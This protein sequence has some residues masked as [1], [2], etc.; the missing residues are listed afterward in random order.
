MAP[1][2]S[3]SDPTLDA[4]DLAQEDAAQAH[5]RRTYLG[6]SSIGHPCSRKLWYDFHDPI[7]ERHD[8]ATLR[9]F[10]DGDRSEAVLI[11]RLRAVS[12]VQLWT[13]DP[14]SGGQFEYTDFDGKFAGHLDGVILGILQAPKT[15]HVWEAKCVN[16]KKFA[17]LRELKDSLG[18][19][20]AF[21]KWDYVYWAQAQVYMRY[22]EL[23][24]H[25]LTVCTPGARA[26]DS[27]RTNFDKAAAEA[28]REKAKRIIESPFQLAKVSSD[29][30]WYQCRWCVYHERC[31]R[32]D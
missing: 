17:K 29:P 10:E 20:S 15:P 13:V 8:A 25:Y 2:P 18:E 28:L 3:Q 14:E 7:A 11:R 16:E 21:E 1:L 23:D 32:H 4:A 26:W 27:C 31:H 22:A 6:M 19:K 5:P 9:R 30:S 24:R 12:G